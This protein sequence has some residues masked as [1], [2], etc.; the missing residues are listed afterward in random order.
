MKI[1]CFRVHQ[2]RWFDGRIF[3]GIKVTAPQPAN[4]ER[5]IRDTNACGFQVNARM[6]PQ[7]KRTGNFIS[8]SGSS[9]VLARIERV[10]MGGSKPATDRQPQ[11]GG[12]DPE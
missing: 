7:V 2:R 1:G 12:R 4:V 10:G 8:I 6:R 3:T 11:A 9:V 5:D